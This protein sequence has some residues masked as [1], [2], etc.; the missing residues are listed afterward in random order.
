MSYNSHFGERRMK[1]VIGVAVL[2]A[3][4][5]GAVSGAQAQTTSQDAENPGEIIVTA[6]RKSESL[7]DVPIAITAVSG[8]DLT[9][10]G[11]TDTQALATVAPG[12]SIGQAN[13]PVT[14]IYLRGVGNSGANAY[15]DNAVAFNVDGVYI[16]RTSGLNGFL[17]DVARVEVLKGP[18]GTL[19]GRNATGGAINVVTN[20][21]SLTDYTLDAAFEIGNYDLR[22]L[23]AAVNAPI[24]GT[25]ALRVA[26]Q[27]SLRD[28][29]FS[30]GYN[31]DKSGGMRAKLRWEPS[32]ALSLVLTADY[33][34]VD[35][36]GSGTVMRPFVDPSNPWL[37]PSTAEAQAAF[38]QRASAV[39][40]A[41]PGSDGFVKADNV[42]FSAELNWRSDLGELTVL[43]AYRYLE[44]DYR[45]YVPGFSNLI[46]ETAE[47]S[48]LEVRFAMDDTRPF[49]V[50]VGGFAYH[51]ERTQDNRV[52]QTV[53]RSTT[54]IND[55]PTTAYALFGQAR[56]NISDALRLTG[57]LRYTT[58]EKKL[59]GEFFSRNLPPAR[60][61][62][63][64]LSFDNVSWR[65][66]V[67]FD[68]APDNLLYANVSTG[69]KAG[70]FF[71]DV[72]PTNTY[73]PEKL[74]SYVL[75]SKNTLFGGRARLNLE[76]FWWDYKDHQESRV[77]FA[78][79]GNIVLLTENVGNATMKGVEVDTEL[80]VGRLGRLSLRGQYLDA[81]FDD[82]QYVA[83]SPAGAPVTACAATVIAPPR[84][85]VDCSGF[86]AVRAPKWSG[87]IG[88]EQGFEFTDGG[89]LTANADLEFASSTYLAI[90]YLDSER[91]ASFGILDLGLSYR[92]ANGHWTL[93]GWVRNVTDEAVITNATLQ[94][95]APGITMVDLRPPRTYGMRLAVS[96]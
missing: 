94:S 15:A 44:A 20:T 58:E 31:D 70:G 7:Q 14:Q 16:G 50:L 90:E 92:P 34:R 46:H 52:E 78:P 27:L 95:F 25:L 5:S 76:A 9:R 80:K 54:L 84:Y 81:R 72:A 29:Y 22:R 49:S 87:R 33:S 19:Y 32:A 60:I 39:P 55:L 10:Q 43:P 1:A 28:G 85:N 86:R 93:S 30:D 77:G 56:L 3:L 79:S 38:V 40:I 51:D 21:P 64:D 96:F 37:G 36:Q 69:F 23:T 71:S 66:G 6:Q 26:G 11:V 63:G 4:G 82:F 53:N 45:N 67:E 35:G 42:G 61:L 68:A 12:L 73:K 91:Q 8:E 89:H 2:T 74:I 41:P 59:A 24:S 65:A 57:G 17:F 48:S 47:Q 83:F 62:S 13:G 18:Q 88:Y 75:G